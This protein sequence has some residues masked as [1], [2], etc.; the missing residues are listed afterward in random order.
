MGIEADFALRHDGFLVVVDELDRVFDT[1]DV[2][3]MDAV[4][5]VDHGR[6]RG[7][8]TGA[9]G[10][11]V[12][13]NMPV[14]TGLRWIGMTSISPSPWPFAGWLRRREKWP[15]SARRT[16]IEVLLGPGPNWPGPLLPL[17]Q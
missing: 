2:A 7:G 10:A 13:M 12:A 9:G 1:D 8:F 16:S 15:S 3:G 17:P 11:A 4:A 5:M 14:S 6:Q